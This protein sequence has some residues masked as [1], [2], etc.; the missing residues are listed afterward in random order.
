MGKRRGEYRLLV[1]KPEGKRQL[2]RLHRKWKDDIKVDRQ[3][4]E[5]GTWAGFMM[6]RKGTG[7]GLFEGHNESP[8][9]IECVEFP[10]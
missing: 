3:E 9:Y 5:W 10:D 2:L 7:G 6:Y 8:S 1:G 4:V